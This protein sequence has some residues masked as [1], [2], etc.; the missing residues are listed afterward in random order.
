M[1]KILFPLAHLI[2]FSLLVFVFPE[3]LGARQN[4]EPRE[5]IEESHKQMQNGNF[6]KALELTQQVILKFPSSHI[7]QEQ[8]ATIYHQLKRPNEEASALEK[9]ILTSPDPSEACPRLPLAY[10]KLGKTDESIHAAERCCAFSPRNADFEFQLALLL[11]RA[12]RL[13]EAQQHYKKGSR[14]DP[15]NIDLTVGLARTSF[16]QGMILE[17]QTVIDQVLMNH[18]DYVDALLVAAMLARDRKDFPKAREYLLRGIKFSPSYLDFYLILADVEES[19]G[20]KDEAKIYY[21]R[22]L[23]LD[24]E[25]A[26]AKQELKKLEEAS[27]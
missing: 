4:S 8:L 16:F 20:K 6:E 22:A 3:L 12:G 7:Y 5:L 9:F 19:V 26:K 2:S 10:Q 18:P 15:R 21:N 24:P 17:S 14:I 11:E 27:K 25:N 23:T 13:A 1:R